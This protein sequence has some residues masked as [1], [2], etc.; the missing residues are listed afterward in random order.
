MQPRPDHQFDPFGP[1]AELYDN[2]GLP[3]EI[4]KFDWN[5]PAAF[6]KAIG[7]GQP[8]ALPL[9]EILSKEDVCREATTW[10]QSIF[11]SYETLHAI[12]QRHEAT[13]QK[14]WLKKTRAQRLKILLTAWPNMPAIHRPDFDAF[15]KES[16]SQR[17]KSTKYRECFMWPYINQEDLLNT[18]ALPLLLNARERHPPSN[19]AAADIDAMHL[20]LVTKAIVPI[21][22]NEHVLMLN[23]MTEN[24]HERLQLDAQGRL[25][26][27]L[28]QC[29][30]EILRDIPEPSLSSDTFPIL[31]EPQLKPESEISGFES[32]S[33]MAAEAPYRVPAQLDLGRIASLLTARASAAEDHLWALR[34][35]PGYFANTLLEAKEH[36]QE[37]LKDLNGSNHPVLTRGRQG[38][39]WGRVI[40]SVVSEAYLELEMFSE[41]S[42]QANK[43][44]A[45]QRVY[46]NDILPSEDLPAEYLEALLRFRHY[47]HQV[48]KGPL[49]KLK[50]GA[51]AAPPMRRLFVRE[52]PLD[53]HT[54]RM[55]VVVRP[56]S[57]MSKVEKQLIWLLCT[58]W[59]TGNDLFLAGMPLI[60]DELERLLQ[61]DTAAQELLSS[62]VTEVIGDLSIVSQC[63]NQL[64]LYHPW[65]RSWES[66]AVGRED[67]LK[68]DY[69][70]QTQSWAQILAAL[71]D[72]I[73]ATSN[74]S[75][76]GNLG[77]PSDGKFNYPI[78]RRR[79]K[80][81][82]EALRK[83]ESNL[84]AF[85]A[86]IDQIMVA[87]AGDLH[88]TAVRNLLSQS[89]ILQRTAEWV[90]PEK[91]RPAGSTGSAQ[92]KVGDVDLY[93]LYQPISTIY[94]GF[95]ARE[96]DIAQPKTKAK[97]RGKPRPPTH[98]DEAEAL[99]RVNPAD[100]QP[101]FTVDAR[102]LKVFRT[103]F[104]N[105]TLTSTPGEVPWNDFLHAMPSVGFTV[106]KLYGSV[107][108]FQPTR[109]DVERSI[110]FHEP[111]PRGKLP[112]RTAR[113]YGR[114]L[115]RAYGWFWGMF[116]LDKKPDSGVQPL[117]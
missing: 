47:L 93:A 115:N 40:R 91:S 28:V 54:T 12:L 113:R 52:P 99:L 64:S 59:E 87:K 107:W 31:P 49:S 60:V 73:P 58:L 66:E 39:L 37:M 24:T 75:R 86:A 106:I 2:H 76:A 90:E 112:F 102:T 5:D 11:T 22:L 21:F 20:C 101:T 103:I 3:D 81:N 1:G 74:S 55:T 44:V 26:T 45:L 95:S 4:D 19:F 72:A 77:D 80:D 61:S 41:L 100:H 78:E 98:I 16:E 18:K 65:A 89:R 33:V 110:Q 116:V 53:A 84:D 13:I 117:Q 35:D 8:G 69:A 88:D 48:A 62:Y 42:S 34:E 36:R 14:R 29:S 32:L 105:P 23:G 104:F 111:H 38:I 92:N 63:F 56:G 50:L 97:T 30:R 17:E 96:L 108:Q 51:V 70:K 68:Q 82:V 71:S 57:K 109:P 6:F 25:L 114:R 9:P 83:A 85:W 67:E 7:A 94:S 79:N 46:A 15:R 10:S 27:F 43:L